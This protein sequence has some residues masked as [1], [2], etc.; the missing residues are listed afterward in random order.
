MSFNFKTGVRYRMPVVFGPSVS[1]RQHPEGRPWKIEETGMMNFQS[2]SVTFAGDKEQLTKLLPPGF[3]LD[4]DPRIN[5]GFMRFNKLYWLA[6][7]GYGALAVNI[8]AIYEGKDETIEGNYMLALWEGDPNAIM[9]GREEM[10]FPKLFSDIEE[11]EWSEDK[12]SFTGA[13]SWYDHT[14]FDI[15]V[16]GL[17]ETSGEPDAKAINR[18]NL[19]Y[20]YM[21]KTAIYGTGGADTIY[22][23]TNA[24]HP[25]QP[26]GKPA[27][28]VENYQ[29]WTAENA[30]I[31]WHRATFDQ[32]P[33]MHNIINGITELKMHELLNANYSK[34]EM[35]G[36]GI[37]CD[38]LRMITPKDE[39]IAAVLH[40][41]V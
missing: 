3:T 7:R 15:E 22:V 30:E 35:S 26:V 2:T 4:G 36:L 13:V 37:S 19:W 6:G 16:S 12:T 8:P 14:F 17:K 21:P 41:S 25:D 9:S 27:I 32:Q 31:N 39:H 24:P 29:E 11:I 23:T 34:L 33:L 5:I 10:G 40:P 38:E 1:P 18:P 20:K 28:K